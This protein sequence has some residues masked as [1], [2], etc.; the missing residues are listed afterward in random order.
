[1]YLLCSSDLKREHYVV[2]S[3]SNLHIRLMVR[4]AQKKDKAAFEKL[5]EYFAPRVKMLT[6]KHGIDASQAEDLMQETMLAVWNKADQFSNT[7]GSVS[8]WIFTIARNK[9]IDGFRKQATRHYVDI[10]EYEIVDDTENV[11]DHILSN[12]RDD[13]VAVAINKL[14]K[15]QKQIV[16]MSFVKDLSQSEISQ[17]LDIPLGTVKSRLR[18]AYAKM[19]NELEGEL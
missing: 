11:E 3:P 12:E 14:P 5:F 10:G 2:P 6:M 15:D 16:S 9:R 19:R 7:R 13:V 1:M 8:S 4:V 18:L 17:K